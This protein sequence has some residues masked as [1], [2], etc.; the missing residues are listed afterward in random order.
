[1]RSKGDTIT[2]GIN[3]SLRIA[4]I[5]SS[6]GGTKTV[7]PFLRKNQNG[8]PNMSVIASAGITQSFPVC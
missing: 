3:R 7:L 2:M 6:G 8:L 5:M 4:C 1:M